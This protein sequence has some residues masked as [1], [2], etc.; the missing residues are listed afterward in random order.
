MIDA[1]PVLI[2]AG[3]T[4]GHVF[5]ALAVADELRSR[6]IPVVWLGTRAGIESRLVPEAGYPI[7]W[8]T[9]TG[10]RG[11]NTATL[12]LAPVRIA[13]ACWQALTVLFRKRP[14]AVLGMGGF[15]S[16]PGGLMAWLIRKPLIVHE[17]NAVAGMT[18][19]ILSR[20]ASVVLQAFPGVF[21]NAT[22]TGNPVRQS[23]CELTEPSERFAQR[24]ANNKLR[25]LVIGGSLGAVKLN[26]IIPQ[27]LASIAVAE[28]PEVIHQ[29]GMKN[30]DDAQAIYKNA[31][32]EAKVE[33]FIDDMPAAYEWADLV[34]CR[35]GAMTVF[36][37]AAAGVASVLVPY[38]YAVDD[39]QTGNARY[40]ETAGAAIVRQQAELTT[41]WLVELINDF[42]ADRN[43]LLDMAVAARKLA[44]P[45]S[46]K[47][48]ADAC[49]S[50]GGIA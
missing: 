19:K 31:D 8:M 41:K 22:T 7:E 50:A 5:P 13:M 33:A 35:S 34:I 12:L 26:E 27:A 43:K 44:I 14:C 46:A 38:P 28:R 30:I 15:A 6:G 23:I 45:G 10:L 47:K 25:L 42:S 1:R 39:H 11:K 21:K 24:E 18:N 2:M 49:Q 36:E 32:V 20:L 17:Q 48:I 4:G 3:G 9:I 16:G 37:L 29:T 40:L